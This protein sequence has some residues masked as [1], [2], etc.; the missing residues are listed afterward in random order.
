[1]Q[2]EKHYISHRGKRIEVPCITVQKRKIIVTGKFIKIAQIF[3]DHLDQRK[4]TNIKNVIEEVKL[5][6]LAHIFTFLEHF[7]DAVEKNNY[8]D[9]FCKD[10]YIEKEYLAVIKITTYEYW[11]KNELKKQTRTRL[12][13]AAR[14]GIKVK[15]VPLDDNLIKGIQKIF[16]ETPIRQKTLFWHY[17]KSFDEVKQMIST[18]A[19]RSFFIGAYFNDDLIGFSK[20]INCGVFG[21][22]N[23]ILSMVKHNDKPVM[24]ALIAGLVTTCVNN[25]IPY[26][27][28]GDWVEGSLGHFKQN[29]AFKK[30]AVHRYY[31]PLSITGKLALKYSFHKGYKHFIPNNIYHYLRNKR[32]LLLKSYFSKRI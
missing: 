31:K 17:G 10:L 18:Y 28:Y 14:I 32:H 22:A 21:R 2:H 5:S 29:N 23:Q 16:N 1:M 4:E 25:N 8:E 3:D 6:K 12:K 15:T 11:Y 19:D 24:N 30:F 9:I 26:L 7:S 13:K 27:S 20:L